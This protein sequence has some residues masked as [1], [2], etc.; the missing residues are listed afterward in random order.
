MYIGSNLLPCQEIG[1]TPILSGPDRDWSTSYKK[2]LSQIP[3]RK[4]FVILEDLL[5][6]SRVDA[7]EFSRVVGFLSDKDAQHV[8]YWSNPPPDELTECPGIGSYARG[9]PYRATVCGFWD[10]ECLMN[11]L[12]EGENPWNFEILGSY[13]TAYRDGFYG[14]TSSLCEHRNMIEKGQ[15]IPESVEWA[16]SE[17]IE[18][19]MGR[20]P[21][22]I[23]KSRI[24]S[25]LQMIYFRSMI[26]V[27]WRIRTGLMN[28]LRRV[29][30]SY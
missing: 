18:L 24:I 2:I 6:A 13:R 29:F 28:Q 25:R 7:A 17:G 27:P 21:L 10:R 30:I 11:L 15:W 12:I 3:E 20:R 26:Q 8:K 9:A 22:L 23:G 5:L 1:T 4:L 16:H 14:L 19:D